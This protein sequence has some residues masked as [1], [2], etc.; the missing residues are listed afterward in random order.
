MI[1]RNNYRQVKK[2]KSFNKL[3]AQ[4]D[5]DKTVSFVRR[6]DFGKAVDSLR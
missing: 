2:S 6:G 5:V 3:V 1:L 4:L